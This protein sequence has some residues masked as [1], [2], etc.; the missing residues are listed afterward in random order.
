MSEYDICY[1]FRSLSMSGLELL[2]WLEGLRRM[3]C[4]WG[5]CYASDASRLLPLSSPS[6]EVELQ[7]DK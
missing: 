4:P 3:C 1:S 7:L 6:M 5:I 2:N